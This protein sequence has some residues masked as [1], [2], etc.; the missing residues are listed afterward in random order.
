MKNKI[1]LDQDEYIR[2]QIE[3]ENLKYKWVS[4][5][6][7]VVAHKHIDRETLGTMLG[8][9]TNLMKNVEQ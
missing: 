8:I 2:N 5:Q 3:L 9:P 1:I 6:E 7:Y 4:V